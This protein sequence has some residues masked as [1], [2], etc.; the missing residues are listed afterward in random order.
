VEARRARG[1]GHRHGRWHET[2]DKETKASRTK[3]K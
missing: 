2:E 3:E 1:K